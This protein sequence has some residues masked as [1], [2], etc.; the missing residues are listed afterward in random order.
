M[1]ILD[2]ANINRFQVL[3]IRNERNALAQ[4]NDQSWIVQLLYA[5][6]DEFKVYLAMVSVLLINSNWTQLKYYKQEFLPGGDLRGLLRTLGALEEDDLRTY[7]AEMLMY[8]KKTA[9]VAKR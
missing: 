7:G 5:F 6:Q 3:N 8:A 2:F 4:I 9:A 1:R